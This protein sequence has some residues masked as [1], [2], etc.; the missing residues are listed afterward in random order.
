MKKTKGKNIKVDAILAN[1]E[2]IQKLAEKVVDLI[3]QEPDLPI[4]NL[5]KNK[6]SSLDIEI[7]EG[8]VESAVAD[9]PIN[10][11]ELDQVV[12][13][14]KT[15]DSHVKKLTDRDLSRAISKVL[16]DNE[17]MRRRSLASSGC[18]S[19]DYQSDLQNPILNLR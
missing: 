14:I 16:A 19:P 2:L 4:K 10:A 9:Y 7:E 3:R 17:I 13:E 6:L 1:E 15:S 5:W 8:L 18:P 11:D 12:T